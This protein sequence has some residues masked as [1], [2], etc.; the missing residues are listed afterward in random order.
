MKTTDVKYHSPLVDAFLAL[1][2]HGLAELV[3]HMDNGS[4]VLC[5]EDAGAYV[6]EGLG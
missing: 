4:G 6:R 5:G 2:P 3:W 1:H